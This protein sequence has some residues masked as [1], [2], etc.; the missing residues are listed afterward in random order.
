MAI[1]DHCRHHAPSVEKCPKWTAAD[2]DPP[3]WYDK[4]AFERL[5]AAMIGK[6]RE[7]GTDRPVRDFVRN[8]AGLRARPS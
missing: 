7:H 8:F 6:D 5:V 1:G 4:A 2:P 3:A